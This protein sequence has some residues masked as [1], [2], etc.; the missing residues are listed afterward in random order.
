MTQM[1]GSIYVGGAYG[2]SGSVFCP[3]FSKLDKDLAPVWSKAM[4]GCTSSLAIDFV[5][6]D[7]INNKIYGVGVYRDYTTGFEVPSDKFFI[8]VTGHSESGT[9]GYTIDCSFRRVEVLT[10]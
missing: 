1:G 10:I 6:A 5:Y 8:F 9:N 2:I 7:N 4:T 3:M